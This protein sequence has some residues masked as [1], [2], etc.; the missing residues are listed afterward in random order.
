MRFAVELL[1]ENDTFPKEVNRSTMHII[2][3]YIEKNQPQVYKNLYDDNEQKDFG[4]SVYLG[5]DVEFLWETVLIPD[6]RIIIN[7]TTNDYMI[8]IGIYNSFVQ[9]K[10]QSMK[11][12]DNKITI[13]R[14]WL[15]EEKQIIKNE[16]VFY[17]KSPIIVR[18]HGD[19]NQK[20]YYHDLSTEIG[21]EVFLS[22]LKYQIK[23]KFKDIKEKELNDISIEILNNK[24]IRVKHY[25]IVIDSNNCTFKIT[26]SNYILNYIY[27]AGSGSRRNQGFG[28]LE[29][30]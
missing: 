10:N 9:S 11:A 28:Y 25:D 27:L 30:K 13:N 5:G 22:N 16:A 26:G 3:T 7:F 1:L 14:I 23:D 15:T 2:K 4:F 24:I 29:L 18:E 8:G 12:Y 6:K 17:T 20:T 21:Q 19:N